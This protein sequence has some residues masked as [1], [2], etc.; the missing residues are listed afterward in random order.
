MTNPLKNRNIIA[1]QP[2]PHCGELVSME[3]AAQA[4]ELH[5][6]F[7]KRSFNNKGALMKLSQSMRHLWLSTKNK[8][9]PNFLR[10]QLKKI[11]SFFLLQSMLTVD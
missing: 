10:L 9:I 5:R 4:D 2:S 8:E 7:L 3:S 6:V 1:T 11:P